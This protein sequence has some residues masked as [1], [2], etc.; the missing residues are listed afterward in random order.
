[1]KPSTVSKGLSASEVKR[2]LSARQRFL[3]TSSAS[4]NGTSTTSTMS[5]ATGPGASTA[6]ATSTGLTR[7][8]NDEF[9][10]RLAKLATTPRGPDS[11]PLTTYSTA[12]TEHGEVYTATREYIDWLRRKVPGYGVEGSVGRPTPSRTTGGEGMTF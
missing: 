7:C 4:M 3:N 6:S 10:E 8:T 12:S 11:A 5:G 2:F 1:M 9:L